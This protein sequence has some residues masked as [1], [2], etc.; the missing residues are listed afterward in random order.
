MMSLFSTS[1]N[2]RLKKREE[3]IKKAA[4]DKKK[5]EIVTSCYI[6]VDFTINYKVTVGF[7]L[8]FLENTY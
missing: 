5:R 8:F 2:N 1:I 4:V 3:E 7:D 6:K